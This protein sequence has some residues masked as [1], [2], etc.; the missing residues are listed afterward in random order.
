MSNLINVLS[1]SVEIKNSSIYIF[2]A[3]KSYNVTLTKGRYMVHLKGAAGGKTTYQQI[4]PGGKGGETQGIITLNKSYTFYL[5]VGGK[6]GD[7]CVNTA[8]AGGY[9]GG[10]IGSTVLGGDNDCATGGSGGSTDMRTIGGEWNDISSLRSRIMVAAG[11]G[12][13]GCWLYSGLGGDGGGI[14]G[15]NGGDSFRSGY[16]I[17]KGG[18]QGTQVNGSNFGYGEKGGDGI[19]NGEGA[20]SG[21]SGYW[22]GYG[23]KSGCNGCSAGGGGGGSSFISGHPGCIAINENGEQKENSIHYSG[24]FFNNTITSVG[25]NDNDG[26]ARIKKIGVCSIY[27]PAKNYYFSKTNTF[28]VILLTYSF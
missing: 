1:S 11:G 13:S 18:A 2:P 28:I 20:G 17:L 9:N 27:S 23:G 7:S 5:F 15:V 12:S 21:G 4:N 3:K 26:E 22:G 24:F 16:T 14:E 25:T 8:G 19:N 6:G 10:S